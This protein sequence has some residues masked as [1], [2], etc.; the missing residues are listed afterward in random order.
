MPD[1]LA[2][3]VVVW[4]F[5]LLVLWWVTLVARAIVV[6]TAW[7]VCLPYATVS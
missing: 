4:H 3:Y 1:G 2:W 6:A 7:L 5:V